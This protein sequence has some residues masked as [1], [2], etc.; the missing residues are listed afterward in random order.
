MVEARRLTKPYGLRVAGVMGGVG[1]YEQF[2]QLKAGSE[3]V[4]GTPGRLIELISMKGGL[5]MRRVTCVVL[6]EA[7]RMF[8]LG[9]EAQARVLIR[10][11]REPVRSQPSWA[12]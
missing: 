7:D 9:F 10:R 4:V 8:S 6:D 3:I 11:K 2:K 5:S 1:K 12:C